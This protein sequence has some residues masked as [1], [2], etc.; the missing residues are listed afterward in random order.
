MNWKRKIVTW[1]QSHLL[2]N[3]VEPSHLRN[4]LLIEEIV[5]FIYSACLTP[6]PREPEALI[7]AFVR[8]KET[9]PCFSCFRLK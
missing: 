2:L 4:K 1:T 7:Q 6:L 5:A 9:F 8:Q 3:A